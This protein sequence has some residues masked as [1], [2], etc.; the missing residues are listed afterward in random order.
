ME[1]MTLLGHEKQL[2]HLKRQV[3]SGELSHALLFSGPEGIGKKKTALL[4]T[5]Y[6]FKTVSHEAAKLFSKGVLPDFLLI[7]AE[8]TIKVEAIR[9]AV[10]F[11]QE[12]PLYSS[13]KVLL[14]DDAHKMNTQAQNKILKTLEEPPSF[15]SIILISSNAS[16]LLDTV[17]SRLLTYTFEMLSDEEVFSALP[18]AH[19]EGD[20][21]LAARFSAGSISRAMQ[22]LED[23]E[24]REL[25]YKPEEIFEA[26]YLN[27]RLALVRISR[28]YKDDRRRASLLLEH[29]LMWLRDLS[30]F[31]KHGEPLSL[32]YPDK[33]SELAR[34]SRWMGFDCASSVAVVEQAKARLE[35][36][37]PAG[38]V[39]L[40]V[41]LRLAGS[42]S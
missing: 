14:I 21:R 28:E 37:A 17:R 31:R 40:A 18:L 20:R 1:R 10:R 27:D 35:S 15:L 8:T 33:R 26:L 2:E 7:E 24:L 25:F 23:A 38:A 3:D 11:A 13:K 12:R 34:Q 29:C 30:L 6:I 32:Y 9:E 5:E 19:A 4:L 42:L 41:F 36:N 16:G 39:L 22:I